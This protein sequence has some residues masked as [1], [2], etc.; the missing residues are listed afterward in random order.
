MKITEISPIS[1][2]KLF[3]N[4]YKSTFTFITLLIF[5]SSVFAQDSK[6][7]VSVPSFAPFNSFTENPNCS[8]ASIIALQKITENLNIDLE[9]IEYPY[10]RILHALESADLDL[11]LI[12]KNSSIK[13]AADYLGPVSYSKVVIISQPHI[14]IDIYD[15]LYALN[16]IAVIRNAQFEEKFDQDAKLNKANVDNYKQA[17]NMLK[18]GRV[19][20]V[21]G[22]LVGIEYALHQEK[23]SKEF[24]AQSFSLG[25]KEWGLHLAKESKF[26]KLKPRLIEAV[27]QNY[28]ADLI[29]QLYQQ[30]VK[31]CLEH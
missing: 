18:H 16:N 1:L 22:S 14:K 30:Q 24:L 4:K 17:V 9:F 29:H 11:A 27:N 8:G 6:L 15:D 7:Q 5:S 10:A 31:T 25:K 21:I 2:N 23:M 20:A 19:D 13:N 28:Q 12:F 26:F 3:I